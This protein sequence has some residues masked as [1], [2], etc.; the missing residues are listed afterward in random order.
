MQKN[1]VMEY[2]KHPLDENNLSKTLERNRTGET[3]KQ[4]KRA[5][6][7]ESKLFI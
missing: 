5:Y 1:H 2:S 3:F 4:E 7:L 6:D